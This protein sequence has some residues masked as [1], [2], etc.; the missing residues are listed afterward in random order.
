MKKQRNA[1]KRWAG[2]KKAKDSGDLA[3]ELAQGSF[4]YYEAMRLLAWHKTGPPVIYAGNGLWRA[5]GEAPPDYSLSIAPD[6]RKLWLEI[7]HWTDGLDTNLYRD[8]LHQFECMDRYGH[9]GAAGAYLVWWEYKDKINEWRLHPYYSLEA[10]EDGVGERG[11]GLRFNREAGI[12]CPQ[13]N[14]HVPDWLGPFLAEY[15]HEP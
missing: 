9:A 12:F 15:R 10:I 4:E 2:G 13:S 7:K 8:K 3:E 14:T 1:W 11:Y 5:T 6:G